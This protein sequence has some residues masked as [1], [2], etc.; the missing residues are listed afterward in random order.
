MYYIPAVICKKRC[1][2]CFY[3]TVKVQS[4]VLKIKIIILFVYNTTGFIIE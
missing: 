4:I 3:F 2:N 1:E